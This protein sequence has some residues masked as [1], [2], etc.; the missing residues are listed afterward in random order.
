MK[1]AIQSL[2]L[3]LTGC[4]TGLLSGEALAA[5]PPTLE[6]SPRSVANPGARSP[7]E[8]VATT[9]FTW[10]TTNADEVLILGYDSAAHPPNGSIDAGGSLVFVARG[11]GGTIAK[12][13]AAYPTS[14]PGPGRFGVIHGLSTDF[15]NKDFFNFAAQTTLGGGQAIPEIVKIA[16]DVLS[17]RGFVCGSVSP[18]EKERSAVLFTLTYEPLASLAQTEEQKR[19]EG[20]VIRQAAFSILVDSG[21]G[22]AKEGVTIRVRPFVR[23][24][25]PR[26]NDKW[27]DAPA[28]TGLPEAQTIVKEVE[29]RAR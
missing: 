28:D 7:D 15:R 8:D 19:K 21:G 3:A 11:P 24:N 12:A 22:E 5:P 1:T 14:K 20:A 25:H 10:K 27:Q 23:I 2:V 18:S 29:S 6:V 26:D 17:K 4:L 13:A 9:A 16:T